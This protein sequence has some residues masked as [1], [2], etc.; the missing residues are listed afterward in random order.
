MPGSAQW[1]CDADW[2]GLIQ[3]IRCKKCKAAWFESTGH[4][5]HMTK[6]L[7]FMWFIVVVMAPLLGECLVEPL[8]PTTWTVY[9]FGGFRLYIEK[10]FVLSR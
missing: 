8:G 9:F 1:I 7:G 10:N 2:I 4:K 6:P 5:L 3:M